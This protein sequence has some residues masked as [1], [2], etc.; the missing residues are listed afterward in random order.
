MPTLIAAFVVVALGL[1]GLWCLNV[2]FR[3]RQKKCPYCAEFI[4]PEA[5]VCKHCGRDIA[6]LAD[7]AAPG[8]AK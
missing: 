4:K 7:H 5:I 2:L 1:L 3:P 8:G 6:S